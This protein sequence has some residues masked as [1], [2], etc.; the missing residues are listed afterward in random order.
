MPADIRSFFGS[1]PAAKQPAKKD[2]SMKAFAVILPNIAGIW[3][4]LLL[5]YLNGLILF[6]CYQAIL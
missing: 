4:C 3:L 1:K 2:V 5:G 6:C